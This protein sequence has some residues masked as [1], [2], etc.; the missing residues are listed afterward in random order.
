MGFKDKVLKQTKANKP[1]AA[2][3]N[4]SNPGEV[5]EYYPKSIGIY[6]E[7]N[8]KVERRS[9]RPHVIGTNPPIH[10]TVNIEFKG[11]MFPAAACWYG[12][13]FKDPIVVNMGYYPAHSLYPGTDTK[14]FPNVSNDFD[15]KIPILNN[16]GI[17]IPLSYD[18]LVP[19]TSERKRLSQILEK[20]LSDKG[21]ERVKADLDKISKMADDEKVRTTHEVKIL[22]KVFIPVMMAIVTE[23]TDDE[24]ELVTKYDPKLVIFEETMGIKKAK[25]MVTNKILESAGDMVGM[26]EYLYG[27]I[28]V[29]SAIGQPIQI[30]RNTLASEGKDSLAPICAKLY[31]D[32]IPKALLPYFDIKDAPNLDDEALLR[33]IVLEMIQLFAPKGDTSSIEGKIKEYFWSTVEKN[34]DA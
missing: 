5:R 25:A 2:G 21:R 34:K 14:I 11:N 8:P 1:K 24:G 28:G 9:I 10:K 16:I 20:N 32:K 7:D 15:K 18:L 33:L 12:K 17:E 13:L 30:F 31:E 4:P 27:D 29:E 22:P 19:V 6:C 26:L 23:E 3:S